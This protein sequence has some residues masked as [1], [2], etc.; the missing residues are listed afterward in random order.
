MLNTRIPQPVSH[1]FTDYIGLLCAKKVTGSLLGQA[2][3][4]P[5]QHS[6]AT[7]QL[8]CFSSRLDCFLIQQSAKKCVTQGGCPVL[9]ILLQ[10]PRSLKLISELCILFSLL[11]TG[12]LSLLFCLFSETKS[13]GVSARTRDLY[14]TNSGVLLPLSASTAAIRRKVQ[15]LCQIHS[16][17]GWLQ[18]GRQKHKSLT[19][20]MQKLRWVILPAQPAH[21]PW[22][23][24]LP[25]AS[26][27]YRMM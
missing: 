24:V 9:L 19:E 4:Q 14:Q 7:P 17:S 12:L 6:P 11:A 16:G 22:P 21:I 20:N 1:L 8:L 13:Q 3:K 25:K 18:L 26:P 23:S 5:L 27:A 15:H 2:E 10:S